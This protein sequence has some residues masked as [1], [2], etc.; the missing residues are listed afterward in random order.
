MSEAGKAAGMTRY[1]M[2]KVSLRSAD[3]GLGKSYSPSMEV[4]KAHRYD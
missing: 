2:Y 3:A 4:A 1:L